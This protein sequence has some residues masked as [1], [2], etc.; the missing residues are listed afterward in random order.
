MFFKALDGP[1]FIWTL[2]VFLSGLPNLKIILATLN[3]NFHIDLG[4]FVGD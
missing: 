2:W 3:I 4:K 1:L